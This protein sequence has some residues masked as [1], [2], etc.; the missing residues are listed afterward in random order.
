MEEKEGKLQIREAGRR[1]LTGALKKYAKNL[2]FTLKAQGTLEGMEGGISRC[3]FQKDLAD[4][5]V[6]DGLE[7]GNTGGRQMS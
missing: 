4:T 7:G 3:A 1:E 2:D 5:R 6:K